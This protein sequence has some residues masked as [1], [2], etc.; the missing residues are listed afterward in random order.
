MTCV[1]CIVCFI[2]NAKKKNKKKMDAKTLQLTEV[3]AVNQ[4]FLQFPKLIKFKQHEEKN[5]ARALR[6]HI[7]LQLNT[8]YNHDIIIGNYCAHTM[9]SE[10]QT[11]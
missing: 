5:V 9:D 11:I 10:Q 6:N 7:N 8:K 1:A 2:V 4:C 3:H